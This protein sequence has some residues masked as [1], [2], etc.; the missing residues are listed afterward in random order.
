MEKGRLNKGFD[1]IG[2]IAIVKFDGKLAKKEKINAVK[3][4]LQ[5]NKKRKGNI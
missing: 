4:L 3:K 5:N 2:G 1:I